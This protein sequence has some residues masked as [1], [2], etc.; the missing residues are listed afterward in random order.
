MVPAPV[1]TQAWRGGSRQARLAS[2]LSG[3]ELIVTDGA[4]SRRAGELLGQAGTTDVIAALVALAAQDRAGHEVL[5]SD[6]EDIHH[7]L[8]TLRVQRTIRTI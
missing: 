3:V 5:T 1:V 8:T 7:L 4:L 2:V 6:L